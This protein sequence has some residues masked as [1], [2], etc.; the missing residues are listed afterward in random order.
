MEYKVSVIIPVYNAEKNLKNTV[1][2]VINQS[3][4]FENIELILVDD[5]STDNSKKII[6]YLSNKY[7]NIIPY[8]SKKNHGAPGFGRNIGLKLATSEYIMF[9]DNDDEYEKNICK[10]LYE[11]IT[12]ENADI[13]CCDT[14]TIDLINK[15]KHHIKYKNGFE[16][17]GKITIENDDILFFESVAVWNKIYKK[18]IIEKNNLKFQE[19]TVADYFIFTIEYYLNCKKMIFLKEYHGYFWKDKKDSLSHIISIPYLRELIDSYT[20]IYYQMRNKNKEKF[21]DGLIKTHISYLL[22]KCTYL[23]ENKQNWIMILNEIHDF[24]KEI[25]FNSK[26]DESWAEVTNKQILKKHYQIAIFILKLINLLRKNTI[27]RKINR[28][29]HS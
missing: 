28:K 11:T 15:I 14:I 8:F 5:A 25:K 3:I 20:Y 1:Q 16:N 19:K 18:E 10:N 23:N 22:T 12:T 13:A 9:L 21:M 4:G 17:N 6:K 2:S 29:Y 26:L 24:E 7:A 27:L